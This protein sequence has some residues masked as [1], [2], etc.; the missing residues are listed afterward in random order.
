MINNGADLQDLA[1]DSIFAHFVIERKPATST[2]RQQTYD[3]NAF[4]L[5][6][7]NRNPKTPVPPHLYRMTHMND[8]TPYL[9]KNTIFD[10]IT[11][12]YDDE[13][14]FRYVPIH[15]P[16][17]S[18]QMPTNQDQVV[19]SRQERKRKPTTNTGTEKRCSKASS[20]FTDHVPSTVMKRFR[21]ADN[22]LDVKAQ[23]EKYGAYTTLLQLPGSIKLLAVLLNLLTDQNYAQDLQPQRPDRMYEFELY[24]SFR[25]KDRQLIESVRA[26]PQYPMNDIT[27]KIK[28]IQRL[29]QFKLKKYVGDFEKMDIVRCI[30]AFIDNYD[31]TKEENLATVDR[32]DPRNTPSYIELSRFKELYDTASTEPPANP[33]AVP[34]ASGS[35]TNNPQAG[36]SGAP[37]RTITEFELTDAVKSAM[38]APYGTSE[39]T[40]QSYIPESLN[41]EGDLDNNAVLIPNVSSQSTSTDPNGGT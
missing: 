41:P 38:P 10:F 29:V 17:P 4:E 40:R 23:S 20:Y 32:F 14:D 15:S 36:F 18:N 28:L 21:G 33:A 25:I 13:P 9:P 16:R 1:M 5:E 26:D 6:S 35:N 24:H 34:T 8:A 19:V 37:R 27:L 22:T 3:R 11:T 12:F 31:L 30:N 39:P 7:S 2:V